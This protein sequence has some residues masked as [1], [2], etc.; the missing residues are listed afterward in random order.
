MDGQCQQ[1]ISFEQNAETAF[2]GIADRSHKKS[3]SFS[4]TGFTQFLHCSH[5]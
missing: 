2:Q 1:G 5:Q 3:P 4:G